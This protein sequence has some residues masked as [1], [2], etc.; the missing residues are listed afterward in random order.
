MSQYLF[1]MEWVI[2]EELPLLEMFTAFG[3]R[4]FLSSYR[5]QCNMNGNSLLNV[6]LDAWLSPWTATCG[7][8]ESYWCTS[9]NLE[10]TV[11]Y[12]MFTAQFH[13]I[14]FENNEIPG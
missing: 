4:H 12:L 11:L 13:C 10:I 3:A 6:S 9:F 14:S 1:A 7:I 5:S 2:I 8:P